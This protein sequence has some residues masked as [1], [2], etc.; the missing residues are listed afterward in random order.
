M[1]PQNFWIQPMLVHEIYLGLFRELLEIERRIDGA[2]GEAI[3]S[4]QGCEF[5]SAAI[6]EA[7]P[8]TFRLVGWISGNVFG[9]ELAA[10]A[11][12]N[13]RRRQLWCRQ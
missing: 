8:R 3:R 2:K 4:P 7:A 6:I 5:S 13:H 12:I 1:S 9:H 11:D 10:C